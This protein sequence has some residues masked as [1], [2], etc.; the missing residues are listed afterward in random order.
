MNYYLTFHLIKKKSA[1]SK[2]EMATVIGLPVRWSRLNIKNIKQITYS[3]STKSRIYHKLN[4]SKNYW[5]YLLGGSVLFGSYL[6]WRNSNTVYAAFNPKKIKVSVKHIG[7][8][9][10]NIIWGRE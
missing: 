6:Q 10:I 4:S 3:Y 8:L 7:N 5:C 1:L 9:F 2:I